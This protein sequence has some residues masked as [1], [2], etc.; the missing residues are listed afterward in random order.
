MGFLDT[1]KGKIKEVTD[2][3]TGHAATVALATQGKF[4][5][6][7]VITTKVTVTSTGNAVSAKGVFVDLM[8]QDDADENLVEKARELVTRDTDPV[9]ELAVGSAFELAAGET[10]TI[11]GQFIVPAG[12]DPKRVWFVRARVQT[13]GNDPNSE[14]VRISE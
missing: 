12:L 14:Y 13:F 8:G 1:V 7:E 10:K 11:D 2:S 3:V 6:A 5:A 4:A 9:H